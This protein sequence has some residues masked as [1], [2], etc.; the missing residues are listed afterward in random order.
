MSGTSVNFQMPKLDE[1]EWEQVVNNISIISFLQGLN[2]GGKVYNGYSVITNNRTKEVIPENSIYILTKD[3]HKYHRANDKNLLS[4]DEKLSNAE[5]VLY[6]DFEIKSA[7]TSEDG[8]KY[9][10]PKGDT[11]SPVTGCYDCIVNQTAVEST[12]N[13]Y[14]YM[15]QDNTATRKKLAGIY[16]TALGRERYGLYRTSNNYEAIKTKFGI[17][18]TQEDIE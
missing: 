4:G 10:I 8:N 15:T 3:D 18:I 11:T 12:D 14:K 9:Y 13:F 6:M 2:I 16:F 7:E 1:P 5:G 17:Q